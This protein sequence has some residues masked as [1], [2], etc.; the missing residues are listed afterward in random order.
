MVLWPGMKICQL[1]LEEVK[2]TPFP[3]P[4]QFQGQTAPAGI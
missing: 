2:G 1:I 3:N 4:P